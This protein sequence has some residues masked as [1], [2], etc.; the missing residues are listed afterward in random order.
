[1]ERLKNEVF[2]VV[3]KV[4]PI[5]TITLTV[6]D[7]VSDLALALEYR[8]LGDDLWY[9]LTLTCLLGPA[10][11]LG[12]ILFILLIISIQ[13][14][15]GTGHFPMAFLVACGDMEYVFLCWKYFE[16]MFESG[17][18]I[19]LQL[20]IMAVDDI[21]DSKSR[22][23]RIQAPENETINGTYDTYMYLA[24]DTTATTTPDD[25]YD[26]FTIILQTIV[27]ITSLFSIS[28]GTVKLKIYDN[29]LEGLQIT[30][31]DYALEMVWNL[32]CISSRV[33]T[34]GLCA[35]GNFMG[36]LYVVA[37]HGLMVVGLTLDKKSYKENVSIC[38]R[39]VYLGL[40]GIG[41]AYFNV[42]QIHTKGC[43]DGINSYRFYVFYW[44][45]MMIENTCLIYYWYE[46]NKNQDFWYHFPALVYVITAYAMS[47]VVKTSH[48][49]LKRQNRVVPLQHEDNTSRDIPNQSSVNNQS[50]Q[51]NTLDPTAQPWTFEGYLAREK[52]WREGMSN[53][54]ALKG[55]SN[56]IHQVNNRVNY[57][58]I[59]GS[60]YSGQ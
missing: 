22:Y 18:Q 26:I 58:S 17:P 41:T 38:E 14:K 10:I 9:E 5:V 57:P 23:S 28:W 39:F 29:Q 7:M 37:I 33:I 20:Y 51:I 54:R 31:M 40:I 56:Q 13:D 3:K 43:S 53:F 45:I 35:A 19:I 2:P 12:I 27:I 8:R 46:F 48:E 55:Q 4:M 32:L 36:F 1:M 49:Y 16:C 42:C 47:F 44:V 6:F 30:K 25:G 21:D 60:N 34:L 24:A 52:M 50:N 15:T 59:I 11:V